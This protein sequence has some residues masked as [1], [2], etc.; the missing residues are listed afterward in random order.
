LK[1]GTI[2]TPTHYTKKAS[3]LTDSASGTSVSGTNRIFVLYEV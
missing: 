1:S 2:I 3:A